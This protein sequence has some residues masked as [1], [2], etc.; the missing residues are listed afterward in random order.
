MAGGKGQRLLPFTDILPK[1]LIP[2]QGKPI[3]DHIIELFEDTGIKNFF[4][5]LNYKSKILKSY[6]R[7]QKNKNY[8]LNFVVEKKPLGTVGSL[9]LLKNKLE[10]DF[11]S[12]NCDIVV[13]HDLKQIYDFHKLNNNDLTI[14]TSPKTIKILYGVCESNAKGKLKSLTEKPVYNFFVNTGLYVFKKNVINLIPKNKEFGINDLIEKMKKEKKNI[15][16]YPISPNSW[17]D[18][19]QWSEYSKTNDFF[20]NDQE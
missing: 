4:L 14:V 3:I 13:K 1:P 2:I 5:T 8:K 18:V 6:F 7:S 12:I 15:G 19:G 20:K 17:F 11:F 9:N 16:V 10:T